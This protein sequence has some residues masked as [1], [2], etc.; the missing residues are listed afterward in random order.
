[1]RA[2]LMPLALWD[3]E[4]LIPLYQ[5]DASSRPANDKQGAA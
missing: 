5:N 3:Q 2:A 4:S 1:M